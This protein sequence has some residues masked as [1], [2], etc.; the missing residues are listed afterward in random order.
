M[1][2]VKQIS[3]TDARTLF[4]L[5]DIRIL[6]THTLISCT[7]NVKRKHFSFLY[8]MYFAVV[9]FFS[10]VWFFICLL[11]CWRFFVDI[12]RVKKL[13]FPFVQFGCVVFSLVWFGL[14]GIYLH[15]QEKQKNLYNLHRA[16]LFPLRLAS[17]TYIDLKKKSAE[18]KTSDLTANA[19]IQ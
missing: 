4:L 14:S 18:I 15:K 1:D 13:C 6:H 7:P 5:A 11:V 10:F 3:S 19:Q 9:S 8:K 12:F 16:S 17:K 2:F